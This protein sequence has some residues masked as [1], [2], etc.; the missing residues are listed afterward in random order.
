[1]NRQANSRFADEPVRR[2]PT[3]KKGH[4][5]PRRAHATEEIEDAYLLNTEHTLLS[6]E[7][8]VETNPWNDASG[9]SMTIPNK[10][11][12]KGRQKELN[13]PR[14]RGVLTTVK[15]SSAAGKRATQTRWVDREKHGCV[16]SRLVLNDFSLDQGRTQ[17]EMIAPTPS[18]WSLKTMLAVKLA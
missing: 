4:K 5:E 7:T 2:R 8:G 12:K 17:P 13:S 14:G 1:M 18:T 11:V 16:K 6:D 3:G 15:R 10:Q 9:Q